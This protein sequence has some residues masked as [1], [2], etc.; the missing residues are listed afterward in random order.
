MDIRRAVPE[1]REGL[2]K[3]LDRIENFSPDEVRCALEVIDLGLQPNSPDYVLL[4]ALMDGKLAG[5]ICYGPSP[6]TDGTWDLYWIASEPSLRGKGIG[7]G[8]VSAMEGDLRRHKARLVRVETSAT[9]DYGPA[10]GFYQNMRYLEEARFR[11]FYK[12]G[13]DLILLKKKL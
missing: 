4:V 8:L 2:A 1:D 11:D 7:A 6:M 5:Y 9:E 13:D 3:L 10:R 12:V